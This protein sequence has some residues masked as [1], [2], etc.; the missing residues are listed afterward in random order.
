[1]TSSLFVLLTL[2]SVSVVNVVLVVGNQRL[3]DQIKRLLDTNKTVTVVRVP[4]SS[5]VR[6]ELL[7]ESVRELTLFLLQAS[8]I[9]EPLAVRI[10]DAQIRSYFYGG[11]AITQ[12][13]LLPF[14]IIV[15]FDDLKI[16][17]VGECTIPILGP[18]SLAR[19]LLIHSLTKRPSSL[20]AA[21][22]AQAPDSALPIGAGRTVGD[23]DLVALDLL[24]PRTTGEL[25][26][27][28]LAIPQAAD[29]AGDE[30]IVGGPVLGFVYV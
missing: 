8:D 20:I 11:P 21:S 13:V 26:N 24:L 1:M 27:R 29:D 16:Y 18:R 12:G 23:T 5:G 19:K 14:S 4:P 15:K 30:A 6:R 25:I 22:A 28:V 9:D 10:K 2:G 7:L 3:E 17:R